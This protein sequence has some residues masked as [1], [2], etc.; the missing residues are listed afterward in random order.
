MLVNRTKR[1]ILESSYVWEITRG[2]VVALRHLFTNLLRLDRIPT[3]EYPDVKRDLPTVFRG[4]QRL[5]K[6]EKG[7]LRCTACML[8]ATACPAQCITVEGAEHPDP[9]IEKYPAR[10]EIDMLR[11]IFCGLC[12]EVCPCAAI[13]LHTKQYELADTRPDSFI[14]DKERLAQP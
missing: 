13:T 3:L 1:G 7:D 8:C 9:K 12:A 2:L 6:N 5:L 11:C 4:R 14:Y 10:Y